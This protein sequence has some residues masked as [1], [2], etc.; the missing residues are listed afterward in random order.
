[1][2]II[3]PQAETRTT[4][5]IAIVGIP[6][7]G[8]SE[9]FNKLTSSYSPVANYPQT[10][11]SVV[12]K[13]TTLDKKPFEII[14]T[15]GISS[16][17]I[18]SEE[19]KVTQDILFKDL[20]DMLLFCG[21]ATRLKSTLVLLALVTEL[22]IPTVF[23]L[24]MVDDAIRRGIIIDSREL[25]AEVFSRVIETDAVHGVG[26]KELRGALKNSV[27]ANTGVHYPS[28]I[29]KALTDLFNLFPSED[30]PSKRPSVKRTDAFVHDRRRRDPRINKIEV[31]G[32]SPY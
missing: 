5:K 25:S 24:N 28:F 14:D 22:E 20:P 8:K 27:T 23:C 10:T 3:N 19:E 11:I 1:M 12:R 6:N 29:E 9:I 32:G 18:F 15:P 16:L 17:S 13:K 30:C 21:D 31:R 26:L 7:T 2:K 4:N